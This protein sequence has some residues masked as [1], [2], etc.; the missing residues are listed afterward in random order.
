MTIR[1]S[2]GFLNALAGGM[3]YHDILKGCEADVYSG[4]QVSS[5]NAAPTGTKLFTTTLA[6]VALTPEI[7]AAMT[8]NPSGMT[9]AKLITSLKIAGIQ[10]LGSTFTKTASHS[11]DAVTLAGIINGYRQTLKVTAVVSG[12]NVIVY[13]PKNSGTLL[14]GTA[15]TVTC[16]ETGVLVIDAETVDSATEHTLAYTFGGGVGAG[17]TVGVAVAA[18]LTFTEPEGT[19]I[20]SKSGTWTG[21]GL[22]D[23]TAGWM[24]FRC[25]NRLTGAAD[26]GALDAAYAD[27]R[28]DCAVGTSSATAEAVVG[29]LLV[30]SGATQTIRSF[31]LTIGG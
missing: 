18:G 7:R 8:I 16:N 3:G 19:K 12:N 29:S 2:D 30:E 21:L 28:M 23:G 25:R 5:A 27:M 17:S 13:A 1:F 11:A 24:R 22:A 9:T 15:I 14:N 20:L 26:S 4:A 10:I 6:S 31:A